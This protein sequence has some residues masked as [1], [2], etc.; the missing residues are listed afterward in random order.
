[1][2]GLARHAPHALR[3]AI[4]YG[5]LRTKGDGIYTVTFKERDEET[6]RWRETKV[7]VDGELYVRANGE[8][9]F[10]HSSGASDSKKMKPWVAIAGKAYAKWR[11]GYGVLG[12][13]VG[14]AKEVFEAFLGRRGHGFEL[15]PPAGHREEAWKRIRASLDAGTPVAAA[16]FRHRDGLYV[17]SGLFAHHSYTVVKYEGVRGSE[18]TVELYNLWG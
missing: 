4:S 17:N 18:R 11:G 6:N 10:G 1:M 8:P 14:T 13:G 16:T 3:T 12:D 9:L 15:A 2:G 7:Q 5:D